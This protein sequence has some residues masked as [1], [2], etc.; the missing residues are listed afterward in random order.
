MESQT[1]QRGYS[2]NIEASPDYAMA[3]IQVPREGVLKVEASA[4]AT[5]SPNMQMK[6]RMKGG[7]SRLLTKESL[8]INEFTAR[9]SEGEVSVAPGP[10]GDIG[11]YYIDNDVVFLTGASYL[12]S[13]PEV[14]LETKF[15]GLMKGFFSG[16]SL[17][18]IRCSG[19]GDLWFNSYGAIFPIQVEDEY[20]VDT[21]H[22]VGFTEGLDYNIE[23]LSGYK[24]FF[25]S[26]EGFVCRFSGKGL[27]WIQTKQ[28]FAFIGWADRYRRV[29]QSSN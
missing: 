23:M 9:E 25:F 20:I 4:M 16:E 26:G 12:A 6:T 21:G 19:R 27:V 2:F 18:L 22:I 5:M 1:E 17:F 14:E 7:F 28:P 15:Q 24:S 3:Q 10:P 29:Q 11:H 13:S 8:F